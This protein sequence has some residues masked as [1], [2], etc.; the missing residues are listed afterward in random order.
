MS[1]FPISQEISGISVSRKNLG[2]GDNAVKSTVNIMADT[3][4]KSSGDLYIRRWAEELIDGEGNNE[5]QK[6]CSLFLNLGERVRYLK[7]PVGLEMLKNP[8]M[9]LLQIETGIIPSLDCD[10]MTT[11]L[12]SLARSAGFPVA[13]RVISMKPDRVFSHVYGLAQVK[14]QGQSYWLPLDLTRVDKGFR[15]EFPKATR[16]YTRRV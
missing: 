12:L 4:R 1:L 14:L 8:K 15:W 3:I 7:D 5:T 6:L 10:C 11:L 13:I 16:V 9:V 2:T